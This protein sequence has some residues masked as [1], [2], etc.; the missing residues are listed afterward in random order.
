MRKGASVNTV[1]MAGFHSYLGG[2]F[3]HCLEVEEGDV[4]QVVAVDNGYQLPFYIVTLP[5]AE[6]ISQLGV[7]T[8]TRTHTH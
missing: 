2:V 3:L 4:D 6:H 7:L 5:K 8:H 1:A